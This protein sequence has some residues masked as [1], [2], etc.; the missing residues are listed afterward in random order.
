MF[1]TIKDIFDMAVKALSF[2]TWSKIAQITTV[3][4]IAGFALAFWDN[5][6]IVY[7]ALS[8]GRFSDQLIP[9]PLSPTTVNTVKEIVNRAPSI[10][11]IQIVNTN[12]RENIRQGIYF[13]SDKPEFLDDFNRYQSNKVSQSP[14]F[15]S[16]DSQ[17][18][19]RMINIMEQELVCVD[20]PDRVKR[21]VASATKFSKQI[22]SISV[23]PRYGKMVGYVNLWLDHV[24]SRDELPEIKQIART[25][26]DEVYDRD[27]M[28][29][30]K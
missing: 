3:L 20:V 21:L 18:N 7:T 12:F 28:H 15:I 6:P 10:V 30:I 26:S 9:M 8:V 1:N 2:L 16:G 4:V 5:R 24:P 29:S 27:V 11:A 14:L 22:C 25:V 23:P 19:D 13:Y 17:N